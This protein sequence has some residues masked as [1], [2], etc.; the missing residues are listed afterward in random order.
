[1]ASTLQSVVSVFANANYFKSALIGVSIAFQV[2]AFAFLIPSAFTLRIIQSTW[3]TAVEVLAGLISLIGLWIHGGSGYHT[4]IIPQVG[5]TILLLVRQS[6]GLYIHQKQKVHSGYVLEYLDRSYTIATMAL[7]ALGWYHVTAGSL[8]S[9]GIRENYYNT[10][11]HAVLL[12]LVMSEGFLLLSFAAGLW[13]NQRS[14][15]PDYYD[16]VLLLAC[17][18]VMIVVLIVGY[19]ADEDWHFF[20]GRLEHSSYTLMVLCGAAASLMISKRKGHHTKRNLIPALIIVVLGIL[21]TSHHQEA[22]LGKKIHEVFGYTMVVAATFRIVEI[23]VI[24]DWTVKASTDVHS[25]LPYVTP[26]VAVILSFVA[27]GSSRDL[28]QAIEGTGFM[29]PAYVAIL[30][31]CGLFYFCFLTALMHRIKDHWYPDGSD[32]KHEYSSLPEVQSDRFGCN[33]NWD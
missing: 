1:M 12:V 16:S 4:Y 9:V 21:F 19:H 31:T 30:Y 33:Q 13:P 6:L 20:L 14:L 27:F 32:G 17:G 3:A 28:C 25:N 26:M 2:L 29:A 10:L 5:L 15:T 24:P 8:E 11:S 7:F 22:M 23:L 18:L